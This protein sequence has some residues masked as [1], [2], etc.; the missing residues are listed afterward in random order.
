MRAHGL[1]LRVQD[2]NPG[3]IQLAG[4]LAFLNSIKDIRLKLKWPNDILYENRKMCGILVEGKSM[5]KDTKVIIGIG[6]N[7][8]GDEKF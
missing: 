3:L 8:K 4:G 5:G 6:I 7:L 1:L 2:I